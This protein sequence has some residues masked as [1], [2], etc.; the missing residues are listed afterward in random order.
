MYINKLIKI[1]IKILW[2]QERIK[3]A[4]TETSGDQNSKET[5]KDQNSM[6]TS[7]RLSLSV[8]RYQDSR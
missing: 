8:I 1:I 4:G 5:S 3:K 2:K 6:E 7:K